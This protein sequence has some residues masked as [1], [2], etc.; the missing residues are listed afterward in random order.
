M[1]TGVRRAAGLFPP[2]AG[3]FLQV[4]GKDRISFLHNILSHDIKGL[5]LGQGRPVCLLDRQGKIRFAA[6]AYALADEV[7]LEM[8]L[9]HL[10]TA[11]EGLSQYLVAE[12]VELRNASSRYQ[13]FRL[14]GPLSSKILEQAFPGCRLPQENLTFMKGPGGLG[15]GGIVRND[16]LGMP[17]FHLWVDPERAAEIS[18]RL[19]KKGSALELVEANEA[20]FDIL[21]IESGQPWPGKEMD[22][23]VILNELGT[24]AYVSYTK[25]CFVGQ[26]I[27]ARIKYRAHPPR[28]LCGFLL[29]GEAVP[30]EK[31]PLLKGQDPIPVSVGVITSACFSPTLGQGL[32]LGF[33]KF[34]EEGP[35]FFVETAQGRIPAVKAPLPFVA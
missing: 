27:V 21:R 34:G 7:L 14:H 10:S 30:P 32:A 29:E 2:V 4:Q 19:L 8:D 15:V 16:H 20:A 13:V 18:G 1:V 33:L 25:G 31:S 3:G 35:N 23:T 9:G 12:A 24:E 6:C 5:A 22:Q 11:L 28:L 17:G 26:E